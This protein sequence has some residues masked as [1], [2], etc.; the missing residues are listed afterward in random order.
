M[1]PESTVLEYWFGVRERAGFA[2]FRGSSR[3][4]LLIVDRSGVYST[5]KRRY[6]RKMRHH[7]YRALAADLPPFVKAYRSL[8]KLGLND[9]P[10][11]DERARR[12]IAR[13]K[14]VLMGAYWDAA[15]DKLRESATERYLRARYKHGMVY[16]FLTFGV[17]VMACSSLERR[18]MVGIF[19]L[20]MPLL[21][22]LVLVFCLCV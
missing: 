20:G 7:S 4:S 16:P 21:W 13:W 12:E 19:C 10:E 2:G 18:I 17:A 9:W 5:A 3:P 1:E 8:H 6:I 22:L 14:H 15:P 11:H